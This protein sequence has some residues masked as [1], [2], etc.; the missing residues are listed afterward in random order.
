MII[1]VSLERTVGTVCAIRPGGYADDRLVG[2]VVRDEFSTARH[3]GTI[4]DKL[5]I[6]YNSHLPV[7]AII[8]GFDLREHRCLPREI[9]LE[10]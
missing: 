8:E 9:Q 10:P 4:L 6:W 7:G 2:D 5:A 1:S 3:G